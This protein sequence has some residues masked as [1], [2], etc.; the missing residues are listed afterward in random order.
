MRWIILAG[1]RISYSRIAITLAVLI[2]VV[3]GTDYF[4]RKT[5]STDDDSGEPFSESYSVIQTT[6]VTE[7]ENGE[8]QAPKPEI[9]I[10][11]YTAVDM[12]YNDICK[13]EL[14]LVNKTY[15]SSFPDIESELSPFTYRSERKYRVTDYVDL[16]LNTNVVE[17]VDNML[18][19]FYD[20]SLCHDVTVTAG[21]R[22][23]EKQQ[24]AL[25]TGYSKDEAGVS[26][27][28]TGYAVDFKIVTDD[29]QISYLENKDK[30][31]WIYENAHKYGFVQRYTEDKAYLTDILARSYHFRYVGIPHAYYMYENDMCLEEYIEMLKSYGFG[32]Q[33]LEIT[34]GLSTYEV[35]YIKAKDEGIT[36]V[37][38]PKNSEYSVS[39]NN[40]DGFIV[41]IL[42]K[43]MSSV[44]TMTVTDEN[45]NAY[46]QQPAQTT[47]PAQT[48]VPT[49]YQQTTIKTYWQPSTTTAPV[50]QQTTIKTYWTPST[51]TAPV[52]Q[53]TTAKTYWQPPA[54]TQPPSNTP[55]VYRESN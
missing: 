52:N 55:Y 8:T 53:Q 3:L 32:E 24:E 31:S 45:G 36:K 20:E 4:R 54:T 39:G 21:Y 15:K 22:N 28:H 26:E 17:A 7:G 11:M 37:H 41:T 2:A 5:S 40:V 42:K 12:S 30:F 23:E 35:Y 13:G 18:I 43:T 33:H 1:R 14:V 34:A 48:S 6:M 27:H 16:K 38:V 49:S 9:D 51:T 47:V 46:T 44:V 25:A 19:D 50:N 10:N 29:M